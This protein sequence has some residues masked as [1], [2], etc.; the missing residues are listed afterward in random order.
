MK[1][2]WGLCKYLTFKYLQKDTPFPWRNGS[3]YSFL[4]RNVL[5]FKNPGPKRPSQSGLDLL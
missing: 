1:L 4:L 3:K 2:A 5:I